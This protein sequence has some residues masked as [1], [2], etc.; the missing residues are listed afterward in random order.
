VCQMSAVTGWCVAGDVRKVELNTSE[1]LDQCFCL[2]DVTTGGSSV[3]KM[4]DAE[5]VWG[6]DMQRGLSQLLLQTK[7]WLQSFDMI[8]SIFA[9]HLSDLGI[10]FPNPSL[11][12]DTTA[13]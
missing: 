8:L 11:E 6:I 7:S 5:T 4:S 10:A 12:P 3:I 13:L 1:V 9:S 2:A